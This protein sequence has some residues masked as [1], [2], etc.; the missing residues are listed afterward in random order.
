[1][2]CPGM[3]GHIAHAVLKR[4][5]TMRSIL[6]SHQE[7]RGPE[8]QGNSSAAE[9]AHVS[10]ARKPLSQIGGRF[11]MLQ[12]PPSMENGSTEETLG[13]LLDEVRAWVGMHTTNL[14]SVW[15]KIRA[16]PPESEARLLLK[17]KEQGLAEEF[18]DF[19]T[20]RGSFSDVNINSSS[21]A[22]VMRVIAVHY[23]GFL[24]NPKNAVPVSSA[25]EKERALW[26]LFKTGAIRKTSFKPENTK[27]I[28]VSPDAWIDFPHMLSNVSTTDGRAGEA[29]GLLQ[30]DTL[31][32]IATYLR[33]DAEK[34]EKLLCLSREGSA[35]FASPTAA[36]ASTDSGTFLL[37]ID[38][39]YS[40]GKRAYIGGGHFCI[41]I[42]RET[43]YLCVKAVIGTPLLSRLHSA[44]STPRT[45]VRTEMVSLFQDVL[46]HI[47]GDRGLFGEHQ[48]LL[49]IGIFDAGK[50][51]SYGESVDKKDLPQ[52]ARADREL[53]SAT[54]FIVRVIKKALIAARSSGPYSSGRVQGSPAP[55]SGGSLEPTPV[56]SDEVAAVSAQQSSPEE[57]AVPL[58]S[59]EETSGGG[60]PNSLLADVSVIEDGTPEESDADTTAMVA[61]S[62]GASPENDSGKAPRHKKK[63]RVAKENTRAPRKSRQKS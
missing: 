48:L 4:S 50:L 46:A 61:Q 16:A 37:P 58:Q 9:K 30:P 6:M 52:K 53:Y 11:V 36:F 59:V 18:L 38:S 44:A 33:N 43:G 57:A 15:E 32:A 39:L 40:S 41:S 19:L 20:G 31:G 62:A 54:N 27:C 29:S 28:K 60:A 3:A 2:R 63:G 14:V 12:K 55:V 47:P 56:V 23:A 51:Q 10:S 5:A 26:F 13:R 45:D 21:K 8:N 34:A 25:S 17:E 7:N 24:W 1:M 42:T 49:P 35:T 22:L